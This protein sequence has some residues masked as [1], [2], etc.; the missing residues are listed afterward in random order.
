MEKNIK[1][2]ICSIEKLS[3]QNIVIRE[4]GNLISTL[5]EQFPYFIKCKICNICVFNE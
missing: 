3:G 5:R 2:S 4:L 1:S